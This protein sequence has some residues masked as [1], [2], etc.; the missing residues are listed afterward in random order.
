MPITIQD[1]QFMK[2]T[3]VKLKSFIFGGY[4]LR[5]PADFQIIC[6]KFT[7]IGIELLRQTLKGLCSLCEDLDIRAVVLG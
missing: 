3:V 4:S 5:N 7:S 1:I 6:T 2:N